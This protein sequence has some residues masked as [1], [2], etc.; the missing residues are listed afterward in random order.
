[1]SEEEK[2]FFERVHGYKL[3][4]P[5][6][7]LVRNCLCTNEFKLSEPLMLPIS[8]LPVRQWS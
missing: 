6:C 3:Q 2:R 7:A 4:D 5:R 1:M 8:G